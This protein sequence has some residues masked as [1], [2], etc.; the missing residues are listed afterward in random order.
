MLLV[1]TWH[2]EWLNIPHY[3][4]PLRALSRTQRTSTGWLAQS[5]NPLC[6][7]FFTTEFHHYPIRILKYSHIECFQSTLFAWDWI[8]WICVWEVKRERAGIITQCWRCSQQLPRR[9]PLIQ[10]SATDAN[11]VPEAL[12]FVP[13]SSGV[14]E[15]NEIMYFDRSPDTLYFSNKQQNCIVATK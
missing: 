6:V 9:T 5:E 3:S 13:T 4:N 1:D 11:F 15:L 2:N 8:N 12:L 7:V 14:R 10:R